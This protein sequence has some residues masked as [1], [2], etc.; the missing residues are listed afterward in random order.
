M[1][2]IAR[3]PDFYLQLTEPDRG[4]E[5]GELRAPVLLEDVDSLAATR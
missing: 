5:L 2:L 3:D 1:D 4:G